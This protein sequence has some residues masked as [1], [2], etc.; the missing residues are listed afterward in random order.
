MIILVD[1]YGNHF[2][3]LFQNM[4]L[5][6]FCQETNQRLINLGQLDDFE[7]LY[8]INAFLPKKIRKLL[9]SLT[10]KFIRLKLVKVKHF[11]DINES[12]ESVITRLGKKRFHFINGWGIRMNHMTEKTEI[13]Q[14]YA[15]RFALKPKFFVNNELYKGIQLAKEQNKMVVGIHIRR[16]DYQQYLGG[17]YFYS[18][19]SYLDI[20]NQMKML[21]HK[22]YKSDTVF[23]VFSNDNLSELASEQLL[24]SKNDWYIDQKLM[25]C[26]DYLIGPPSTFTGWASYT[27]NVLLY[28]IEDI[29]HDF[30]LHDFFV[31]ND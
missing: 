5:E 9:S 13:H 8:K 24:I 3:I 30:Q 10:K 2:N 25:T 12:F 4:H 18:I 21:I 26:C 6:L 31:M 22:Q 20:I 23:T 17:K 15:N 29:N 11:D 14:I 28:H 19:S 7:D 1:S 27:G 16:G